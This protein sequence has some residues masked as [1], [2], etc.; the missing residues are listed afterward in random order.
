ML[1]FEYQCR[2][3]S[4]IFEF[5]NGISTAK[6]VGCESSDVERVKYMIF[7]PSKNFCPKDKKS[8]KK[9]IRSSLIELLGENEGKCYDKCK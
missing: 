4:A 1:I 9:D 6:C 3:C 2:S 8:E 5:I 7:T